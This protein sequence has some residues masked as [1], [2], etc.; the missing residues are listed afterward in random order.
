M[1]VFNEAAFLREL[2]SADIGIIALARALEV[3]ER[4]GK[5]IRDVPSGK[6]EH[7]RTACTTR[8]KRQNDIKCRKEPM[9]AT[10][11]HDGAHNDGGPLVEEKGGS[12]APERVSLEGYEEIIDGEGTETVETFLETEFEQENVRISLPKEGQVEELLLEDKEEE[13]VIDSD[14]KDFEGTI[15]VLLEAGLHLENESSSN[16]LGRGSDEIHQTKSYEEEEDEKKKQV[17]WECEA[18]SSCDMVEE[19]TGSSDISFNNESDWPPLGVQSS[20]N[21]E[22]SNLGRCV[23]MG[24]KSFDDDVKLTSSS[25]ISWKERVLQIVPESST[26]HV[27]VPQ[28]KDKLVPCGVM[29]DMDVSEDR[30]DHPTISKRL[31]N[32]GKPAHAVQPMAERERGDVIENNQRHDT[33]KIMGRFLGKN[34]V[35]GGEFEASQTAVGEDDDPAFGEWIHPESIEQILVENPAGIC[36]SLRSTTQVQSKVGSDGSAVPSSPVPEKSP[37]GAKSASGLNKRQMKRRRHR[38]NAIS[39]CRTGCVT[40]DMTVQNVLMLMCLAVVGGGGA[41]NVIRHT[42]QWVLYC[43]ACYRTTTPDPSRMFCPTCGNATLERVAYSTDAG[44]GV[45][46]LHFRKN[47]QSGWDK[48]GSKYPLPAPGKLKKGKE[49][50][51]GG[52]LLR[53][54]QLMQGIWAQKVKTSKRQNTSSIFG[55]HITESVGICANKGRIGSD[56]IVVG[57]GKGNPNASRKGKGRERRGESKR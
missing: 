34:G 48:R 23:E 13:V 54:D 24:E 16:S 53:E 39:R 18:I 7:R 56:G 6:I 50:F 38:A 57:F 30:G 46:K 27:P 36:L 14:G 45:M 9:S 11:P 1:I 32:S 35:L 17:S 15:D 31:E 42:R 20:Q 3:Q 21:A 26:R 2:S 40:T 4:G 43:T 47:R 29:K 33:R 19:S 5:D 8:V 49:R 10:S 41:S 52:L 51:T 28:R 22:S 12:D 55:E 37:N 44:T 25:S